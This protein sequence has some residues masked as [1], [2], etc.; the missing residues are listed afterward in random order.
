MSM[1]AS[2]KS[3]SESQLSEMIEAPSKLVSYLYDDES[4][5]VCVMDKAW[6]GIHF[7]LNGSAWSSV[8]IEGSIFLGGVPVSDEDVGYGP[9]RYFTAEQTKEISAGL[10]KISE[11]D[12]LVK[13][14][15]LVEE[16]E[17]YP[18]FEDNEVDRN[19]IT[20]NFAHLK[21]FVEGLA[22]SGDCLLSFMH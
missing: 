3:I 20:Q 12:L 5:K 19:Y 2:L 13:Y 18:G 11:N 14:L 1:I 10:Q 15:S 8:S 9:A 4:G 16:P 17:I 6:H 21:T 22:K 7:L